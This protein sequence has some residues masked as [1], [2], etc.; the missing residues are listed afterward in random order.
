[1]NYFKTLGLVFGLLALL[2]PVY[3]H[4]IP[5]DENKFLETFYA[6]KR[7]P[8]ILPIIIVG[9]LLVGLTWYQHMTLNVPNSIYLTVLFSLTA[10]KGFV[11][12]LDYQRF[13]QWVT[14][15]LRKDKGREIVM[16]DIG[17]GVFGLLIVTLTIM[18]Y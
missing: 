12:M 5:W 11:L 10:V 9:L 3:M 17:A 8:W 2:K 1:M 14:K 16:V 6:E 7:P 4:L 15:M 18:F 13:H